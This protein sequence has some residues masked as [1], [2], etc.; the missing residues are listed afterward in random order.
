MGSGGAEGVFRSLYLFVGVAVYGEEG[1][2]LFEPAFVAAGFVLGN[3]EAYEG[4][5]HSA[6]RAAYTEAGERCH[7][8]SCGDEG[9]DTGDSEGS[10][11]GE[12]AEGSTDDAA[13]GYTGGCALGS[14]GVLFVSEGSGGFVVRQEDG[15]IGVAE[16]GGKE[17]IDGTLG[18]VRG[19]VDAEDGYVVDGH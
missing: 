14:F 3:A 18:V 1:S 4:S 7:D 6:E 8:G 12:Q 2:S 13:R 5:Y 19:L 16:T 17:M 9:T 15:D 10:Y 11:A